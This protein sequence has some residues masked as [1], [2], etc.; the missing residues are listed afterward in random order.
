MRDQMPVGAGACVLDIGCGDAFVIGELARTHPHAQF[1]GVDS[2]LTPDAVAEHSRRLPPNVHLFQELDDVP[3]ERAASLVLLMDVIEHI[4]NDR[5]FLTAL[6][7]R[8]LI[9]AQTRVFVTVPAFQG[10]FSSHDVFLRHY[11]RYSNAQLRECLEGTGL[12]VLDIGYFF[13]SLLP[14]RVLQVMKERIAP[15]SAVPA[16]TGLSTYA[17]GRLQTS[18]FAGVL[19]ADATVS[20]LLKR[21]GLRIPG[22]SNFA[23]CRTSA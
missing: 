13:S 12:D 10:L 16:G 1:Y 22:L 23:V 18:L 14:L 20:L 4:E 5:G 11:R 15:P 7:A 17:G 21:I 8:P 3:S 2:A 19:I 6:L 9:G